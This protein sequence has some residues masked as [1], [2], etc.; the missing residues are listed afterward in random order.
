MCSFEVGLVK[1][2]FGV[3]CI[4]FQ[5]SYCLSHVAQTLCTA[6]GFYRNLWI[7]EADKVLHMKGNITYIEIACW[8][9]IPTHFN[10]SMPPKSWQGH[11]HRY[12]EI[13]VWNNGTFGHFNAHSLLTGNTQCIKVISYFMFDAILTCMAACVCLHMHVFECKRTRVNMACPHAFGYIRRY[14][15]ENIEFA[16]LMIQWGCIEIPNSMQLRKAVQYKRW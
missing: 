8:V 12:H 5:W 6:Y 11:K 10:T 1:H 9:C 13:V 14:K 15:D 2:E 7:L 4:N 3:Y 16:I